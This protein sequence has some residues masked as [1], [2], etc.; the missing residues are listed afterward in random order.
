[1][2]SFC[3]IV[4]D[5][6]GLSTDDIRYE[7]ERFGPILNIKKEKGDHVVKFEKPFSV[8]NC[9][10]ES[11]KAGRMDFMAL[12]TNPNLDNVKEVVYHNNIFYNPNTSGALALFGN[13][14]AKPT[15]GSQETDFVLTQNTFYGMAGSNVLFQTY[16]ARSLKVEK[17]I[18]YAPAGQTAHTFILK[19]GSE[20][21][22]VCILNDNIAFGS[23]NT[24]YTHSNS[25]FKI[26]EGNRVPKAEEDLMSD[27]DPE[28]KDFAPI[29]KYASYGAQR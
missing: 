28:H 17:N 22:V 21:D 9:Y 6:N 16:G 14:M 26:S 3:I 8:Y 23:P 5:T 18:F 11:R 19:T 10:I 27:A 29:A 15:S 20:G 12:S 2:S 7:L 13:N 25:L 1:M 24:D 4:R